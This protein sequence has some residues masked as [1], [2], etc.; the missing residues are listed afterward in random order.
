VARGD[1]ITLD[2]DGFGD[3]PDGI[4]RLDNYIVFVPGVLP[5]ERVT[6]EITSAARKF[7]RGEL[8][9]VLV[10]AK[11]RT[12]PRCAHFLACGGCH[13]QHQ[14]YAEQLRS[15]RQ[16]ASCRVHGRLNSGG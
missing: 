10:S 6:V 8:V 13:R 9:E 7:G 5:G 12:E 14:V 3:G 11:E 16:Q 15:K 1:L 4:G 2:I